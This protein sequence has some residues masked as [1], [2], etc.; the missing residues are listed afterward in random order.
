MLKSVLLAGVVIAASM[1]TA[2]AQ[3]SSTTYD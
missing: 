3:S 1:T 2:N